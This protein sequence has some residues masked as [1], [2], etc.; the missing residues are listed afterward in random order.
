MNARDVKAAIARKF[1]PPAYA[2]F[3]EVGEGTGARAGRYADAV[4]M[5]LWPSRGCELVGFEVKVSRGD[6]LAELKQPEKSM[7]IQR[8]MDRWWIV[9]PPDIVRPGELPPTWGH[10]VVKASGLHCA[11]QAPAL[12]REQIEPPFLAAL[13]RRADEHARA[14]IKSGIDEAMAGER[15]AIEA[16]V[17]RRVE[18]ELQMRGRARSDAEDKLK[19]LTDA[20]G[21]LPDDQ[22]WFDASGFGRAAALVHRTGIA[23]TYGGIRR[24]AA[25]ARALAAVADELIPPTDE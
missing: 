10:F 19:A 22:R 23:A 12:P 5:S 6:W 21:L 8:F 13:L 14:A 2:L 25:E 3:Y 18:R 16:E 9:T 17:A 20:C 1:A 7:P 11:T 24:L 4:A 15:A